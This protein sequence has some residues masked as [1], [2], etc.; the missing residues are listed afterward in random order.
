MAKPEPLK[1]KL[2]SF[3]K[4]GVLVA[5]PEDIQSAVE[6]LKEEICPCQEN[7]GDCEESRALIDKAFE[8]VMKD[9]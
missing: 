1:G 6:W 4:D 2:F 9:G 3:V 7:C 8:D 5:D